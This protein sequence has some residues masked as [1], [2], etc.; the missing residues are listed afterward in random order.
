[1]QP[2]YIVQKTF[3]CCLWP[4]FPCYLISVSYV[5]DNYSTDNLTTVSLLFNL[6]S[7]GFFGGSGFSFILYL[8][9]VKDQ[10]R[11]KVEP[12][13]TGNTLLSC[14]TTHYSFWIT[15]SDAFLFR[16]AS[17]FAVIVMY[18]NRTQTKLMYSQFE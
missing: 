1:M 16:V 18:L 15:S 5:E 8:Y 2:M 9:Y 17:P 6:L 13:C 7:R 12:G 4:M 10:N 11:K 14:M 3:S